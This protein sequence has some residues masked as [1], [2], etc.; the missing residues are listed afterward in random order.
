MAEAVFLV[1]SSTLSFSCRGYVSVIMLLGDREWEE[2][3][4]EYLGI[5]PSPEVICSH[6]FPQEN[7]KLNDAMD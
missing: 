1:H 7:C 5:G 6:D 4:G 3:N 2:I